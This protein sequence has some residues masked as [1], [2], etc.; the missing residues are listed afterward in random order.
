MR[1]KKSDEKKVRK[2][3]ERKHIDMTQQETLPDASKVFEKMRR[4]LAA[5]R[6]RVR[7]L[8]KQVQPMYGRHLQWIQH[9]GR[10]AAFYGCDEEEEQDGNTEEI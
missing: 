3:L 10:Q 9:E 8:E 2:M 6:K 5:L 1:L 4:E 7:T